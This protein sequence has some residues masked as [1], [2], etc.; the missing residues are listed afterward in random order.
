MEFPNTI[1]FFS[2]DAESELAGQAAPPVPTNRRSVNRKES[3]FKL[4][5]SLDAI[6]FSLKLKL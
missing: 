1:Y 2:S 5:T 6:V 3:A 4:K